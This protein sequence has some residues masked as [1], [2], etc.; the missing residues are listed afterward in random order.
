M[1]P[2]SVWDILWPID[3]HVIITLSHEDSRAHLL[4]LV[5]VMRKQRIELIV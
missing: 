5:I 2:S 3:L 1:E 4:I